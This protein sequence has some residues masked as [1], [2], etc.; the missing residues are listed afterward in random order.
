MLEKANRPVQVGDLVE[1]SIVLK[2]NER[3]VAS[4]EVK[5]AGTLKHSAGMSH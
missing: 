3:V 4:C 5:P 1:V 2:S